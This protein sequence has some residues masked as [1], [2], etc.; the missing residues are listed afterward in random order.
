M[1]TQHWKCRTFKARN[2]RLRGRKNSPQRSASSRF[3]FHAKVDRHFQCR[4][5]KETKMI[6]ASLP[7]ITK[8][9]AAERIQLV[10]DIWDT[11]AAEPDAVALTEAQMQV[12]DQRLD[13]YH[14]NPQV[15]SSWQEV[16]RRV[17]GQ[18]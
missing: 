8:L 11:L 9:S 4:F 17:C 12:L 18:V 10:E 13:D 5:F 14:A 15:G 6:T 7:E 3:D 1:A 2:V 16:R